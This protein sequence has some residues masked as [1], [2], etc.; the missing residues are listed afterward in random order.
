MKKIKLSVSRNITIKSAFEKLS[1]TNQKTLFVISKKKIIG[2]LS[3]G[4]IR[5]HILKGVNINTEINN[6]YNKKPILLFKD[7]FDINQCK[8]MMIQNNINVIP[9]INKSKELLDYITLQEILRNE[10]KHV[11]IKNRKL[12]APFVIIAGGKG[13]RLKPFTDI[14]PKPLI[15]LGKTTLIE[16]ILDNSIEKGVKNFY[17]ILNYM[18]N[19]IQ[20]YFSERSKKYNIHFVVEKKA[21]NTAGGLRLL[22]KKIK[23]DFFLINCDTLINIDYKN[24]YDFHKKNSNDLTIVSCLKDNSI[25]YGVINLQ[26]NGE[27]K[28]IQEKPKFNFLVN[29]G[30]YVLNPK[31][32]NLIK[33]NENLSMP[34]LIRRVKSNNLK[35]S[36]YP[37]SKESWKDVGSWDEYNLIMKK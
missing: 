4:D 12:K 9:I 24:L 25:P 32:L 20:S 22:K 18:H 6:I 3:D 37:I 29:T 34:E 30:F 35:I 13:T 5:K 14:L 16:N 15:P 27:F 17:L 8:K 36:I 7:N 2:T 11:K 26:K 21:L 10:N 28:T 31:I 33:N 1:K 23:T 19:T